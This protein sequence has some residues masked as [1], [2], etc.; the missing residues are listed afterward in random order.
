[1]SY[2]SEEVDVPGSGD[3]IQIHGKL[4]KGYR[5]CGVWVLG[6]SLSLIVCNDDAD[7]VRDAAL[8]ILGNLPQQA[9]EPQP[10]GHHHCDDLVR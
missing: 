2:L 7:V 4:G 5:R 6:P 1:M 10:V 3:V 9:R 8:W